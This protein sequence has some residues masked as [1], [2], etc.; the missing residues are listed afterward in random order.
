MS[1]IK[2]I[3]G[4]YIQDKETI[5]PLTGKSMSKSKRMDNIFAIV[6]NRIYKFNYS[7]EDRIFASKVITMIL[8]E[9]DE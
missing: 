8:E 9:K 3:L 4:K 2:Q 5:N 7:L 6:Q 1:N